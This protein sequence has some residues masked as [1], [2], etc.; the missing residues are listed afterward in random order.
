M[1]LKKRTK[2]MLIS[3]A[4]TGLVFAAGVVYILFFNKET[5]VIKPQRFSS[6][7]VRPPLA[8]RFRLNKSNKNFV[9]AL[10][11]FDAPGVS[12]NEKASEIRNQGNQE[13]SEA[14]AIGT[15]LDEFK[16]YF[17][18]NNIFFAADTNIRLN[19]ENAAFNTS[20]LS[21][22]GY[23]FLFKDE[24]SYSTSL[25]N[26]NVNRFANPFDKV[27][28]Q[29]NDFSFSSTPEHIK[30]ASQE[31]N[32]TSQGFIINTFKTVKNPPEELKKTGINE[33]VNWIQN[34]SSDI[35]GTKFSNPYLGYVRS[36]ISDHLPV[37]FNLKETN[38]TNNEISYTFGFWNALNFSFLDKKI[39]KSN[40]HFRNTKARNIA[41]L[42]LGAKFDLI[43]LVEINANTPQSNFQHFLD[44][45]NSNTSTTGITYSGYLSENTSSSI[46]RT[47][48][49]EKVA[50][51]Y[52][53]KLLTLDNKLEDKD[54]SPIFYV[55]NL[56]RPI[57]ANLIYHL[58]SSFKITVF[59]QNQ[60]I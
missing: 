51:I 15:V 25:S 2:Y 23:S 1:A 32:N 19:N 24:A 7:Y 55:E 20:N 54:F 31:L 29:F 8:A 46:A 59:K 50:L 53:N 41:D 43:G 4:L 57:V 38:A 30:K 33:S 18:T 48:Q 52:N 22:M 14:K 40:K 36:N 28:Y 5:S 3:V 37:G 42:I 47:N 26:R 58:F 9:Y 34:N 56:N 16:T 39:E 60:Y 44:Y 12:G 49:V 45:L 17:S 11:H 21:A 27:I 10:S 35:E 13:V 6:S